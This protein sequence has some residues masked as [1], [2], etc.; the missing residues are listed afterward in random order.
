MGC[1]ASKAGTPIPIIPPQPTQKA[2]VKQA[3]TPAPSGS[4]NVPKPCGSGGPPVGTSDLCTP[5]APC[6]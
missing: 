1:K 6:E 4:V 5:N 2:E 3:T